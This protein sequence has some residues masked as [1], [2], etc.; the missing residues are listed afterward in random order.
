MREERIFIPWLGPTLNQIWAGMHWAKRNK[1][2]HQAH[3]A[4]LAAPDLAQFTTP[5]SLVFQPQHGKGRRRLDCTNYAVTQKAIEDGLVEA[6][7]LPG[8]SFSEV[9]SVKTEAPIRGDETGIWVTITAAAADPE[10]APG[11][12]QTHAAHPA[13][14]DRTLCGI[15]SG[16]GYAKT[17]A[18]PVSCDACRAVVNFCRETIR[19][20]Q[21]QQTSR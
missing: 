8:D 12:R 4:C 18:G 7:I 19:I 16:E 17:D 14:P 21:P 15:D 3:K 13:Q 11:D 1:I 10:P 9:V 6:G 2:A 20:G 5:V